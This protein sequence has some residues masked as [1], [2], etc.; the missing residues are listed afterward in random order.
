M[1]RFSYKYEFIVGFIPSCRPCWSYQGPVQQRV[2][3][4][5]ARRKYQRPAGG[6]GPLLSTKAEPALST[7]LDSES[8]GDCRRPTA[9]SHKAI[10]ANSSDDE[11]SSTDI[12]GLSSLKPSAKRPKIDD[13]PAS[14]VSNAAP[15]VLAEVGPATWAL[16]VVNDFA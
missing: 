6:A 8:L 3:S 11:Y 15:D 16:P 13:E 2:S 1:V 12:F 14:K 7:A 10:M 9:H 4:H 5:P